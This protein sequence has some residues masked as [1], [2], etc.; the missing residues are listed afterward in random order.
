MGDSQG[1]QGK[2]IANGGAGAEWGD[3]RGRGLGKA[4]GRRRRR[5][6]LPKVA[7]HGYLAC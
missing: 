7:K 3:G 6:E 5:E 4:R 1:R 2:K